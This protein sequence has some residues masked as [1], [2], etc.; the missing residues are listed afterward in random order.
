MAVPR[1][2]HR[3]FPLTDWAG[4]R[5]FPGSMKPLVSKAAQPHAFHRPLRRILSLG[6][7]VIG[8]LCLESP[9]GLGGDG[10]SSTLLQPQ[11]PTNFAAG[12]TVS[13]FAA[14]AFQ[15]GTDGA[16]AA[17]GG[18]NMEYFFTEKIGVGVNY[19][20]YAFDDQV[21]TVSADLVLRYPVSKA[22][23]AP[24]L[25]VGG[26]LATEG[27]GRQAVYRLGGGL[28]VSLLQ[29]NLG[30]FADG[31]YNWVEGDK[32]FTIAR[33]GVRLPF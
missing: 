16:S 4:E 19:A 30:V 6:W 24:Y 25:L 1:H 31:I 32:D 13:P 9:H 3:D 20:V 2:F 29:S 23:V 15:S 11:D 18:V 22:V 7:T 33:L 21:H 26:G 8:L 27:G 10:Q 28:D 12:V 14:G 17:G 5:S